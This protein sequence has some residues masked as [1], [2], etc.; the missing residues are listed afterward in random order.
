MDRYRKK[1]AACIAQAR[2]CEDPKELD[3]LILIALGYLWLAKVGGSAIQG[4][5]LEEELGRLSWWP[6]HAPVR[7]WE[8]R[9]HPGTEASNSS[10][11]AEIPCQADP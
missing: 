10:P 4:V 11:I 1:A 9:N 3:H 7:R 6:R 5:G 8:G 2:L